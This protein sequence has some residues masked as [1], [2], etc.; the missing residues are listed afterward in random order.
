MHIY[1]YILICETF[2][3]EQSLTFVN[4]PGYQFFSKCCNDRPGGGI[5]IFVKDGIKVVKEIETPF[6]EVCELL[7]IEIRVDSKN[8]C[9]GKLYR[10][11]N[12]NLSHF[13]RC[14]GEILEKTSKYKDVILGCDHNM[15]LIKSNL[16]LPTN[17]FLEEFGL[18]GLIL[19]ILKPT[20]VTH[21]TSTL[22]DNI[23]YGGPCVFDFDSFVLV[24]DIS[25]HYP[26]LIRI[27]K[28]WQKSSP[29][30]KIVTKCKLN[31]KKM[32]LLNQKL[33]FHDWQPILA[34]DA[35]LSYE[36]LVHVIMNYLNKLVPQKNFFDS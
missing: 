12:T 13:E 10:I 28:N 4:I 18:R 35:N 6:N 7:F 15:D 8:F 33:L 29:G 17:H 32:L 26:C 31:D 30:D 27:N 2:L 1:I 25:D 16:H 21:Q 19:S 14:Y 5:L 34:M 23:F 36:Y 3:S 24:D 20:R 9:V 11:P 22:I